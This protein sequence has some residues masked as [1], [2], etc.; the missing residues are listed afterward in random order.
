MDNKQTNFS[1]SCV[2]SGTII[3]P[4]YKGVNTPIHTSTSYEYLHTE[5]R[6]PRAYNLPNQIAVVNKLCALEGAEAGLVFGSGIAATTNTIFA[7]LN[8]GDEILVQ[9]NIY[10]GT[11]HLVTFQLPRRGIKVTFLPNKPQLPIEEFATKQTK[12]V[13]IETP[14]NPLLDIIDIEHTANLCKKLNLLS[15]IDNTF[16]SPY[17][18]NPIKYGIDLVMHSGTKY[19]AGHSDIIFGAV[20]GKADLINQIKPHAADFGSVLDSNACYLVE[21]SMKTLD[22]RMQRHC[23][24]AQILAEHLLHESFVTKVFYPGLTSHSNYLTAKKQMFAFGAVITFELSADIN[25]IEFQKKLKIISPSV[26]LGGVESLI[27]S[28]FLTSHHLVSEPDRIKMGI[29]NQMVRFSVGIENWKDLLND[30][31]QAAKK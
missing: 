24:N 12:M 17:C 31:R 23:D 1:T 15:F 29:T 9:A 7:F 21:R 19:L 5:M 13:L 26:S 27:S 8:Q 22:V 30:L 6:Y 3:D 20:V 25:P 16:A 4:I 28:P 10:G 14:A 18:Q 2:H 11:Y